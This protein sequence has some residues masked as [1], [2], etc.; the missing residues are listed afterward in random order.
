[1]MGKGRKGSEWQG[2]EGKSITDPC[3]LYFLS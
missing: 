3:D 1:M 2:Y